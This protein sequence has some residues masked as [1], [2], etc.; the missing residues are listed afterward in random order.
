[1]L[2]AAA[3]SPLPAQAPDTPV[4]ALARPA[5]PAGADTNDADFYLNEGSRLLSRAPQKAVAYFRTAAAL[6]P[7][8]AEAP[9]GERI[10]ILLSDR[11][12]L[13]YYWRGD[14]KVHESPEIQ[15]ADSLQ[16]LALTRAPLF[17]RRYDRAL[18][19]AIF[20]AAI[21]RSA[22]SSGMNGEET[23]EW[24]FEFDKWINSNDA[25]PYLRAWFAYGAG[26]FSRATKLY[27]EA[28]K[29]AR[30]T[31]R[32][33]LYAERARAF[34]HMGALDSA[35]ESFRA[36]MAADSARD[37]DRLVMA[38]QSRAEME[39]VLGA[40]LEGKGDL[41]GARE[42]YER[43]LVQ[44]LAYYPAHVALGT[45]AYERH[46]TTSA[47]H[48]MREAAQLATHDATAHYLF[49]LVLAT[50]GSVAEGVT[51]LTKAIDL[52]PHWA[53]PHLLLARLHDAADM[54]EEAVPYWRAFLA[55]APQ[56]HP[57]HAMAEQRLSTTAS[58]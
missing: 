8:S 17:F 53:E 16:S 31:E 45:L 36:S 37:R 10:A 47:V 55:R 5:L 1:M 21:N 28:I 24:K 6:D 19:D 39:H 20:E 4:P 3:I 54:R 48:E 52:A 42:A 15:R 7:Q 38:L 43:A 25:P 27:A 49:G 29:R 58:R 57:G 46:D 41:A 13:L 35:I 14:R 50:T 40:L 34:A 12:R 23:A 44:D 18:L 2:V 9:Y 11:N 51:E 33:D 22:R 32:G 30:K 56:R 26:D